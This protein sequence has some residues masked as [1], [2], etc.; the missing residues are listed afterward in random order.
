MLLLGRN[1][2]V[3]DAQQQQLAY[4]FVQQKPSLVTCIC[5]CARHSS[6]IFTRYKRI[7]KMYR[8]LRRYKIF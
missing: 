5:R 4:T 3:I 2:V 6:D 1:V 7:N 8:Y